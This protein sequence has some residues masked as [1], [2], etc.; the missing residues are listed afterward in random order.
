MATFAVIPDPINAVIAEAKLYLGE[1][2]KP[3]LSNRS[4]RIDYWLL[5][6]GVGFGLP[7]CSAY[8]SAVGRQA[9]GRAWPVPRTASVQAMV[10]WAKTLVS[11]GVWQ[12]KPESGDLFVLYFDSLKRYAHVGLVITVSGEKFIAI[13]GNTNT[14]GSR[15][16]YG[17]YIRER[18]ML[19]TTRF[20]RWKNMLM[21]KA[22]ILT[23]L[24]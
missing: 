3:K 13:E 14:D 23:L 19:P 8:V 15:D 1:E 22:S 21:T 20:I 5:E 10:D 17:V 12:E 18:K 9:L 2:E 11:A 6:T 4:P 7:W 24:Q 16:G